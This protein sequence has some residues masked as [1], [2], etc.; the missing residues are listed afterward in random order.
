MKN[1]FTL[2]IMVIAS[3]PATSQKIID[4]S[5]SLNGIQIIEGDFEWA[6]VVIKNYEGS[7]IRISGEVL[8]N[9]GENNDAH[10]LKIER[11]GNVLQ[12]KSEIKNVKSLPQYLTIYK[13]GQEIYVKLKDRKEVNWNEIKEVHGADAGERCSVGVLIDVKLTILV[14][15]QP[16]LKVHT[17]YG[18]IEMLE[19][20]NPLDLKSTYGHLVA[21]LSSAP[22]K[23]ACSLKSTY[24]FVDVAVPDDTGIDLSAHTNHGEIYSNLDWGVNVDESINDIYNSKIVGLVNKGGKKVEVEALYDNVYLRRK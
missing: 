12:I 11:Q 23:N 7:D 20:R 4:E 22:D 19:C 10:Q 24:G 13:G 18:S 1:I 8:I 14:P 5:F 2:F 16:S 15:S 6:D 21:A 17:N 9:L 3:L